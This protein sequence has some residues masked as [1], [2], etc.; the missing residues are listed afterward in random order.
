MDELIATPAGRPQLKAAHY[1]RDEG[2]TNAVGI[3]IYVDGGSSVTTWRN[4]RVDDVREVYKTN[5]AVRG[6]KR[7]VSHNFLSDMSDPSEFAEKLAADFDHTAKVVRKDGYAQ[8][9]VDGETVPPILFKGGQLTPK[10]LFFGGRRMN[11]AGVSL[12]VA[13]IRFGSV[14]NVEGS[15][16]TNGFDAA[17]AVDEVRSAMRVAPDALYVVTVRLDAPAGW[18]DRH[19][20]EIW[21]TKNGDAVY[22]DAGHVTGTVRKSGGNTWPWVSY[23]SRVWREEVKRILSEF[24]GELKRTG[25]S[26][27]IVGVH[28]AGYHDAQFSTACPDWSEPARRAFAAS[29]EKDFDRFLK[30]APMELQDDIA[31]HVREL[32]GKQIVVF[33]WCMAAFGHPYCASHDIREFADSK[34]IDIIVPQP[35]YSRRLPGYAVG[36]KLPFSSLHLNGK[37]L[38]HEHDL[39]TYSVWPS[40]C[41]AVFDAGMGRVAD[42]DEWRIVDRKMAGQMIARRTGFWY[43]DMESGW[44]DSPEI[45]DD[46]ASIVRAARPIYCGKPHP[47]RPT[48]AF[49]ID[50][51]DLLALQRADGSCLRPKADVN[52]YVVQIAASGVPFDMYMK[53]DIARHPDIMSRYRYVVEYD[54]LTHLRTSKEI[55]SEARAAGAYVPLPPDVVQVDMSGDFVSVHC[56]VPGRYDFRLPR[57]CRVVNMKSGK[58]EQ[59]DGCILPIEL[60]AGQTS[61]FRLKD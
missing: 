38:M 46:I 28:L 54:R 34:E 25:L 50:E 43:Y 61:W 12:L 36:V 5:F 17:K 60:A 32:F 59:T 40:S 8:L 39:R 20:N 56:L 33:R 24:I 41:N 16:T 35:S 1:E 26:K 51:A 6:K 15:W 49:V 31:R 14:P 19:T 21:R 4:V 7:C 47:W 27:R 52:D 3:A 18:C 10:G 22:G 23:H 37:L 2:D 48:A 55:N 53:S 13:S 9:T 30:L 42:M 45:A 44:Y 29:G 11:E 58:D 57:S